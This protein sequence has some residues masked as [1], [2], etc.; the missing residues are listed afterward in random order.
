MPIPVDEYRREMVQRVLREAHDLNQFRGL[1][2]ETRKRRTLIN[3]LLNDNF[4]PEL[5]REL[6]NMIDFDLYDM[7]AHHGY[8][9]RAL[10]RT[11]RNRAYLEGNGPGLTAPTPMRPWF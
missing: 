8:H 7:F 1:W 4:S 11:E 3:H 2:I 6:D 9:A 5:V 10:K